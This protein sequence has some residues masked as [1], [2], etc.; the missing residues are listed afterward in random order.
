MN[1][2]IVL[3]ISEVCFLRFLTM[4]QQ[5]SNQEKGP[6]EQRKLT[7]KR[8]PSPTAPT[9]PLN[10]FRSVGDSDLKWVVPTRNSSMPG[11]QSHSENQTSMVRADFGSTS[12]AGILAVSGSSLG[13]GSAKQ[14]KLTLKRIPSTTAP[15]PTLN[16]V[17]LVADS[18]LKWVVP[19]RNSAMPGNQSRSQN[20]TSTKLTL[21]R[22][23][24][25]TPPTPPCNKILIVGDSHLKRLKDVF[26]FRAE[27]N[28]IGVP[29][30]K[31]DFLK[32]MKEEI[33]CADVV[34]VMLGGND[35]TRHPKKPEDDP[36]RTIG[37]AT[38][39]L[40]AFRNYLNFKEK[41]FLLLQVIPRDSF[42]ETRKW[43][44]QFNDR[45]LLRFKP[46]L[47]QL[48]FDLDWRSDRVHLTDDS[49]KTIGYLLNDIKDG[50]RPMPEVVDAEL[51]RN[52]M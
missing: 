22:I 42:P 28:A 40:R 11:N 24:S 21:R 46:H 35:I 5:H 14:K 43:I 19:T 27:I 8:I 38:E 31:L 7:L 44:N 37:Q 23:P 20:Q 26:R 13:R 1:K 48:G 9:P 30:A 33:N 18:N 32:R 10:E 17:R 50:P 4:S 45:L 25:P 36:L 15:T 2:T 3:Y 47:I 39:F 41:K 52:F 29:G 16:K 49:Y 6:D 51:L 34:L 12:R